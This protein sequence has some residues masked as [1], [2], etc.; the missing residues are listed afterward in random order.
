VI[1]LA[2]ATAAGGASLLGIAALMTA[3]LVLLM[4][5]ATFVPCFHR[6]V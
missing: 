6:D 2:I 4:I 5:L 3:A 1:G